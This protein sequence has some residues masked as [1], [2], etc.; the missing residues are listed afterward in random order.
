MEELIISTFKN[1]VLYSVNELINKLY[2]Q[3]GRS[4]NTN[5]NEFIINKYRKLFLKKYGICIDDFI[6]GNKTYFNNS[7]TEYTYV[8]SVRQ[9]LC[10]S[11]NGNIQSSLGGN[12]HTVTVAHARNDLFVWTFMKIFNVQDTD[13]RLYTLLRNIINDICRCNSYDRKI[14]FFRN[15]CVFLQYIDID[16]LSQKTK[17]KMYM[18]INNRITLVQS[19]VD[20][21]KKYITKIICCNTTSYYSHEK[22]I[23]YFAKL[24]ELAMKYNYRN[25]IQ[26]IL[27]DKLCSD[28]S[29]I[30]INY[31]F[32]SDNKKYILQ[33]I[34]RNLFNKNDKISLAYLRQVH[35]VIGNINIFNVCIDLSNLN[36]KCSFNKDYVSV[37]SKD[38][39]HDKSKIKLEKIPRHLLALLRDDVTLCY[40]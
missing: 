4:Y 17:Y 16:T 21:L 27:H 20:K 40:V 38:I 39:T 6:H 24:D 10:K 37:H 31:I 22:I 36:R 11:L 19:N 2:W 33:D 26:N 29:N 35:N 12:I 32:D 13:D 1:V 28:T 8:H 3:Q 30:I 23:R 18:L 14:S 5:R 34:A 25:L 9:I 15:M 7:V